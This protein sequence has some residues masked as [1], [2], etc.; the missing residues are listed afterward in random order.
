MKQIN[1]KMMIKIKNKNTI[2]I[3]NKIA[4]IKIELMN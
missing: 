1:N 2:Q 3:T 4:K